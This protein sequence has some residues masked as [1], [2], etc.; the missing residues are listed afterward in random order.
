ML[1]VH[2]AIYVCFTGTELGYKVYF[3]LWIIVKKNGEH[4]G[5]SVS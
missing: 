1:L 4:I 2:E 3:L 5:S